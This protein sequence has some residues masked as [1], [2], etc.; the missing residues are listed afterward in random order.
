MGHTT[1]MWEV[2][3]NG[4]SKERHATRAAARKAAGWYRS[5]PARRHEVLFGARW[6]ICVQRAQGAGYESQRAEYDV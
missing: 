1:T 4:E 6:S 5:G 3:V 2:I